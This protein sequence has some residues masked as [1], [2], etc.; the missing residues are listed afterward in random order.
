M[1]LWRKRAKRRDS[2]EDQE[3]IAE[4]RQMCRDLGK[5]PARGDDR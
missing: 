4:L 5:K 3:W 1:R 2:P